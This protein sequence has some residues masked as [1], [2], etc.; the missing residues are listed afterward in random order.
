MFEHS[1]DRFFIADTANSFSQHTGERQSTH[2]IQRFNFWCQRN[3][4]ADDKFIN[5]RVLDVLDS[6]AGEDWVRRV[7]EYAF[8]ATLFHAGVIQRLFELGVVG[9]PEFETVAS[10]S[11]GSITAAQWAVAEAQ[12]AVQPPS[13]NGRR[14][15]LYYATQQSV[16]PP[17]F[18]FFVNDQSLLHFGYERYVENQIRERFGFEGTPLRLMF[19]E[20]R[21]EGQRA[22]RPHARR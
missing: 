8:R 19:R 11:G 22:G 12:A 17:L 13:S 21:R 20:Q 7:S 2:F 6:V 5:D 9:R 14:L 4:I 1:R 15:K 16:K 10:V 18:V 3:G